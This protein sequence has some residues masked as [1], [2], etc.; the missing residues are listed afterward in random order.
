[1]KPTGFIQT[2]QNRRIAR[3]LSIAC[4]VHSSEGRDIFWPNCVDK[5][6]KASKPFSEQR[7]GL[8]HDLL[9]PK[10]DRRWNK[11]GARYQVLHFSLVFE[12]T[13]SSF[14]FPFPFIFTFT[15]CRSSHFDIHRSTFA[16]DDNQ[17]STPP[18][19][20]QMMTPSTTVTNATAGAG[21]TW[22]SYF[23]KEKGRDYYHEPLSG[24]TSWVAPACATAGS[25]I[26]QRGGN[27]GGEEDSDH[28]PLAWKDPP[29]DED[30]PA[31]FKD[32]VAPPRS[33]L[34]KLA[35]WFVALLVTNLLLMV[36]TRYSLQNATASPTIMTVAKCEHCPA[37]EAKDLPEPAA[38]EPVPCEPTECT[39]VA[40]TPVACDPVPCEPAPCEPCPPEE[41]ACE[42]PATNEDVQRILYENIKAMDQVWQHVQQVAPDMNESSPTPGVCRIPL[43]KRVLS[44]CRDGAMNSISE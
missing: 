15:F 17:Q 40:C 4:T 19:Q 10:P 28:S 24:T 34:V 22:F 37:V 21:T 30:F 8:D 32:P 33:L 27:D 38:C 26:I 25:P 6:S 12:V 43:A 42:D 2:D 7:T 11:R 36:W 39:P 31:L 23:S 29:T 35:Y 9:P 20:A 16:M 13:T 1:M 18:P 14:P 41:S 5:S 3:Q 44:E